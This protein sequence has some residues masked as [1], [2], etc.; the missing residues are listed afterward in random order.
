VNY[1][2]IYHH[3]GATARNVGVAAN[4][5]RKLRATE[6]LGTCTLVDWTGVAEI[7]RCFI[8]CLTLDLMPNKTCLGS[9]SSRWQA[10]V[11]PG[12][13]LAPAPPHRA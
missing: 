12:Y 1:L 9:L 5:N 3:T 6:K 2:K 11:P 10:D 4:L 13:F 8:R 7:D